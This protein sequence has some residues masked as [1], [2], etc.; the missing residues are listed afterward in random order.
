M[1]KANLKKKV[2]EAS[3]KDSFVPRTRPMRANIKKRF[4]GSCNDKINLIGLYE[5]EL[6]HIQNDRQWDDNLC[7][8]YDRAMHGE[9]GKVF[10]P[11]PLE[12]LTEQD[13]ITLWGRYIDSK[14]SKTERQRAYT[15]IRYLA[16]LAYKLKES[17]VIFWGDINEEIRLS[18]EMK[19]KD[20][21]ASQKV[22][23]KN[24]ARIAGEDEAHYFMRIPK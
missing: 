6:L 24:G 8:S 21:I 5:R 14:P 18:N 16:D 7:R 13:Y 3:R 9:F 1:E 10:E 17:D 20:N 12:D 15:M 4:D 23:L 22:M 11:Y 2:R 19:N